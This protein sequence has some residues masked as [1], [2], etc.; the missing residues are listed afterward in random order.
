MEVTLR[1]YEELNFFLKPDQK[2]REFT[3][4]FPF[5]RSVKDLIE[6]VG[7]PHVE[8]DLI[9]A[10]SEPVDFSYIPSDGDRL[11]IYPVFER[12][13][14]SGTTRLRP[15]PLRDPRFVLDVH[16]YTLTRK[17][18]MLGFDCDYHKYRDDPELARISDRD[19]RILL[20]RDRQ[21]LMRSRVQRGLYIRNTDP[22]KQVFEVVSRLEL[23]NLI[24]PF[25]RC[26]PCNGR[27]IALA[28]EKAVHQKKIPSR[29]LSS[30]RNFVRCESCGKI[31]W[32]GAHLDKMLK[33]IEN[34]KKGLITD[35]KGSALSGTLPGSTCRRT[36]DLPQQE[37]RTP[38]G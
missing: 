1:C 22:A 9:L 16:L 19:E 33:E 37:A 5:Q 17:L 11:S 36:P 24:R 18:R 4:S 21:L 29:V 27:L 12:F 25:S 30:Q 6:S 32:Q 28:Y 38:D 15:A 2:K 14:L 20:T 26:I 8:V 34:L 23:I 35:R 10:N 13:D 31:Y 3:V 7:I